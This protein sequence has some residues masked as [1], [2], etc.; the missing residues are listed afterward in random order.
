LPVENLQERLA[1]MSALWD[2]TEATAGSLFEP[3]PPG[4]YEGLVHEFDFFEGGTPKQAFVKVRLQV[5]G[6]NQYAGRFAEIVNSLEDPERLGFLKSLFNTLAG[7]DLGQA[8]LGRQYRL[9]DVAPETDFLI[10]LLDVPVRFRVVA[11]KKLNEE[12]GKPY[13]NV[14]LNERLGQPVRQGDTA[15]R[16]G[17][18]VAE[19]QGQQI[20]DELAQ[21]KS[22]VPN[23]FDASTPPTTGSAPVQG[24]PLPRVDGCVCPAP[25]AGRFAEKCPIPG[26]GI[27]F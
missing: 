27:P 2:D 13:L 15:G 10:S 6:E 23:D 4:D 17:S 20:N 9:T 3:P 8:V 5:Q 11:S 7:D 14:Y 24:Q 18:T 1:A 19:T 21:R 22:D 25:E 26:H 16:A 12:T